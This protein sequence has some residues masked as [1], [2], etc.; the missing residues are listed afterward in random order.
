[1]RDFRTTARWSDA[2]LDRALDN[3]LAKSP[4]DGGSVGRVSTLIGARISAQ[5]RSD[6]PE[7]PDSVGPHVGAVAS[8]RGFG[9]RRPGHSNRHRAALLTVAAAAAVAVVVGVPLAL[10]HQTATPTASLSAT[11]ASDP[12]FTFVPKAG[13]AEFN[14]PAGQRRAFPM[15]SGPDLTGTR[16]LR[17]SDYA[18]K[19]V[20][21]NFWGSWCA[22]CRAE[23]DELRSASAALNPAEVTLLGVD[24]K[25]TTGAARAFSSASRTPYPSISD[26]TGQIW[27]AISGQ[28]MNALPMT[29]VLDKQH[30]VAHIWAHQITQADL[31]TVI[32]PLLA[33]R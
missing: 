20:V 18:G 14:Y 12:L 4:I 31:A 1:M 10:F 21:I 6:M 25:D 19:V 13:Q 5:N 27:Q 15:V 23:A 7:A 29:I 30:R 17:M 26:P 2:D 32:R 9:N 33:D 28:P 24:V 22:P 3:L 16:T 11:G 8:P